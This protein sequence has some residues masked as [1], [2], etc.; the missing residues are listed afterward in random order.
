MFA[1]FSKSVRGTG[2]QGMQS[3]ANK[4]ETC[5]SDGSRGGSKAV[6]SPVGGL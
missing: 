1:P 3:L 6:F 5:G 4:N 2:M